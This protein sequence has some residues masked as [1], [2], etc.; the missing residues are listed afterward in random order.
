MI[1]IRNDSWREKIIKLFPTNDTTPIDIEKK[2]FD[3]G[4]RGRAVTVITK[5]KLK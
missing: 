3:S 4:A 1:R 2:C 5:F